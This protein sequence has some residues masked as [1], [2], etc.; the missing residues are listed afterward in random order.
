M[1][2]DE[3]KGVGGYHKEGCALMDLDCPFDIPRQIGMD[4]MHAASGV[5]HDR[6][7]TMFKGRKISVSDK[8]RGMKN[9][10]EKKKLW[11]ALSR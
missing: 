4:C 1:A 7:A 2:S 8:V 9:K 11:T 5:I 6:L 10:V 3:D